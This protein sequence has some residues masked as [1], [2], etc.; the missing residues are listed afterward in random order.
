MPF[1]FLCEQIH[2]FRA[3]IKIFSGGVK[4]PPPRESSKIEKE[5]H[6]HTLERTRHEPGGTPTPIERPTIHFRGYR[7][8]SGARQGVRPDGAR[9]GHDQTE[10]PSLASLLPR[11]SPPLV[12][13]GVLR[14]RRAQ[15]AT[16]L[17][18]DFH[19]QPTLPPYNRLIC[20]FHSCA[21]R[22]TF[23]EQT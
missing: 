19:L 5:H 23:S 10:F 3:D 6:P 21:N 17:Q 7:A 4:I 11:P 9:Q 1:P 15:R 2:I 16:N 20:L 12:A 8:A 13:W 22:Y 18:L 14:T